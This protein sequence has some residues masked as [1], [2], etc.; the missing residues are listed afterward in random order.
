MYELSLLRKEVPLQGVSLETALSYAVN[1]QTSLNPVALLLEGIKRAKQQQQKQQQQLLRVQTKRADRAP[2]G[3]L[4]SVVRK[5]FFG[6][7][8]SKLIRYNRILGAIQS[9]EYLNYSQLTLALNNINVVILSSFCRVTVLSR[10]CHEG[11][12]C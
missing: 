9:R 5:L 10:Q 1:R 12:Y 8:F 11:R 6:R 3:W 2:A 4:L 7:L